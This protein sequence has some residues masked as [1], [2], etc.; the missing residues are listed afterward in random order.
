MTHIIMS[1]CFVF[2][3]HCKT[4]FGNKRVCNR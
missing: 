3:S 4:I 1:Q 2:S